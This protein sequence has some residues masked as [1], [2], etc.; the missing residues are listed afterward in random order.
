MPE[1]YIS[2]YIVFDPDYGVLN[3]EVPVIETQ[4]SYTTGENKI[5]NTIS[6]TPT[7]SYVTMN[8]QIIS[9]TNYKFANN[10]P[11]ES[12]TEYKV[13]FCTE[14][15]DFTYNNQYS[16]AK[17]VPFNLFF[18][19]KDADDNIILTYSTEKQTGSYM[20]RAFAG[21]NRIVIPIGSVNITAKTSQLSPPTY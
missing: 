12:N 9:V 15:F 3:Q 2:F 8:L 4:I 21:K 20:F 7:I 11:F 5:L 19:I 17:Q 10:I 16:G 13:Q 1:Q 18:T 6:I 14:P